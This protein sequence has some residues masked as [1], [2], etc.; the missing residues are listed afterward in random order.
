ML[1]I[2]LSTRRASDG[3]EFLVYEP[4]AS[5]IWRSTDGFI[6]PSLS[7]PQWPHLG[8][9]LPIAGYYVPGMIVTNL[10]P[11]VSGSMK[12]GWSAVMTGSEETGGVVGTSFSAF[13]IYFDDLDGLA[14]Y[15]KQVCVARNKL[16]DN[17]DGI[18][19]FCNVIG[20]AFAFNDSEFVDGLGS[21]GIIEL[22]GSVNA[23]FL[24]M[25]PLKD[26]LMVL[27]NS[28][29]LSQ[30]FTDFLK[31]LD[32]GEIPGG[33]QMTTD[34]KKLLLRAIVDGPSTE[35]LFIAY[36]LM[37]LCP[38]IGNAITQLPEMSPEEKEVATI[39]AAGTAET[40]AKLTSA[41]N[42]Y[43]KKKTS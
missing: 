17:D 40:T 26:K 41:I 21:N 37:A 38:S 35:S 25:R 1:K 7:G 5:N 29:T 8:Y 9:A 12:A 39:F 32:K 16:F 31:T 14:A 33:V 13:S 6:V 15:L 23:A 27:M 3:R 36:A 18:A 4:P 11:D 2:A 19:I 10:E 28:P 42:A 34:D 30:G 20:G 24:G 43:L 22:I